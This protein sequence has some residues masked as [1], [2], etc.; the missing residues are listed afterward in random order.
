MK[1]MIITNQNP[2]PST[3]RGNILFVGVEVALQVEANIVEDKMKYR[4]GSKS[5]RLLD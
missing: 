5:V 1:Q 4:Y 3:N 2:R